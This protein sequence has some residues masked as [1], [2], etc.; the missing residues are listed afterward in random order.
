MILVY[1]LKNHPL[2]PFSLHHKLNQRFIKLIRD[3][4]KAIK[5]VAGKVRKKQ[6]ISKL[7]NLLM[8]FVEVIL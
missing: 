2:S 3:L 6:H 8:K 1:L 7:R 5:L 4:I